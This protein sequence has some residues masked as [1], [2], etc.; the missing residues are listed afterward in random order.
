LRWIVWKGIQIRSEWGAGP[1]QMN[2][3]KEKRGRKIRGREMF[4][5][6]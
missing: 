5:F 2:D 1:A 3:T 4:S 6:R